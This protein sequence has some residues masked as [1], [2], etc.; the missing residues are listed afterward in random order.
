MSTTARDDDLGVT[1]DEFS[2]IRILPSDEYESADRLKDECKDFTQSMFFVYSDHGI[3][4]VRA[5]L[6]SLI[7]VPFFY[8]TNI[9]C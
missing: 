2:K 5:I 3:I 8:L 7:R 4:P 1:F 6:P 9:C